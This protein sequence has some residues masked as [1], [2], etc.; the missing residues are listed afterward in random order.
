VGVV[1]YVVWHF[2]SFLLSFS[3]PSPLPHCT[4]WC[5]YLPLSSRISGHRSKK[6]LEYLEPELGLWWRNICHGQVIEEF[7]HRRAL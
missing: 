4:T 5:S 2:L 6:K 7:L 3:S 1:R